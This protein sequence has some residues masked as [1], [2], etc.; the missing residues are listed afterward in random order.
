MEAIFNSKY[1]DQKIFLDQHIL[2]TIQPFHTQHA[3]LI[4]SLTTKIILKAKE[5]KTKTPLKS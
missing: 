3:D 2:P 1:I 5:Y 4:Q